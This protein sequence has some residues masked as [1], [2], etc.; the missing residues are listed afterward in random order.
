MRTYVRVAKTLK[1]YIE[2]K[3]KQKQVLNE[4]KWYGVGNKCTQSKNKQK[5]QTI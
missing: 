1:K 3:P 2:R 4:Y 5:S